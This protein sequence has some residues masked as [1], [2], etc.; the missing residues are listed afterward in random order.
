[1][2]INLSSDDEEDDCDDDCDDDD[3]VVQVEC[4]VGELLTCYTGARQ[5]HVKM[6]G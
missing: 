2:K 3:S 1:M 4:G 6:H 5:R